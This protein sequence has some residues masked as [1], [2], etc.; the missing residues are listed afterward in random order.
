[1]V[2]GRVAGIPEKRLEE[3]ARKGPPEAIVEALKGKGRT[4]R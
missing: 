3:L 4:L 1:M 2:L